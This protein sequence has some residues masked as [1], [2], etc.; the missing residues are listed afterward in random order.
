[1][2]S[3]KPSKISPQLGYFLTE[4]YWKNAGELL[5]FQLSVKTGYKKSKGNKHFNTLS[6]FYYEKLEA[7]YKQQVQN[8]IFFDTKVSTN[9]LYGLENE[10]AIY[11]YPKPKSNLGLR[12]YRFFTY[13]IRLTYYAIGL[14]I[15][16]ITQEF[17]TDYYRSIGRIFSRYGGDLKFDLN[18]GQLQLNYNS[19]WYKPHYKEFRNK[20]RNEVKNSRGTE[21]VIHIDIQNYFEEISIAKLLDFISQYIKPSV[22]QSMRFDAITRSQLTEFFNFISNGQN[23]IPQMDNDVV[24]SYIGY[25]YLAFADMLIDQELMKK[26]HGLEKYSIIRYMDDLYLVLTFPLKTRPAHQEIC[27]STIAAR[28]ADCLYVSLGLRLN[29]KTRLFWLREPKDKEALLKNLKKVSPG[30]QFSDDDNDNDPNQKVD[31]ILEQ[32]EQL[33]KS[34]LDPTFDKRSDVDDEVLKE[35]YDKSVNQLISSSRYQPRVSNIF[36]GF[37]FDL[38]VAQ[39]REILIILLTDKKAQEKFEEFLLQ[40]TD[41][42]SRDVHLILSYLCQTDFGS[43]KQLNLLKSESLMQPIISKFQERSSSLR[44]SGYFQLKDKQILKFVDAANVIEQ[45][46]LRVRAERRSDYSVALNHLLNEVQSICYLTDQPNIAEKKYDSGHVVDF[47]KRRN[48]PHSTLVKIRNL[49]DRRNKNPVSHADSIS[50]PVSLEEYRDYHK[51]VG[52][53]LNQIL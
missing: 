37:N 3:S 52:L 1:M 41:L 43:K 4:T 33:K 27:I 39:P 44:K 20:V 42:T 5:D 16:N 49:F 48:V 2:T 28:I 11:S 12:H 32:L 35:I 9:L 15:L 13:P 51:H 34:S 26:E 25:L 21:V 53:C 14:Y 46:R 29:T 10:F 47:L 19:V 6:M 31:E 36:S 45:I 38:I 40:K 8:V 22:Q 30:Y 7:R 18:N 17:I 23:G 50:W 24:S